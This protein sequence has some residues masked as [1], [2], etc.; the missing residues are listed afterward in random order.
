[1][2]KTAVGLIGIGFIIIL[3]QS[4]IL[5]PR[6]NKITSQTSN[7]QP[8]VTPL[9]ETSPLQID[10]MRKQNYPGSEILIEQTL[11]PGTNYHQYVASYTSE[12]LKINALLTVPVGEKPTNGWP[13]IVF[14][15]GYIAPEVY[16][17]TERYV[18]YVDALARSGYIV[19]KPDYRGNGSSEGN[20]DGAYYSPSYTIDV[21]NA[22]LSIKKFKDTDPNKIGMWGHSMGGNI[23]LR[24]LVTTKDVKAAVIWGGVV[25]SYDDLMNNWQRKVPYQPSQRDLA[26]RN[27]RRGDMVKKF[28]TPKDNPTFWNSI[29]PTAYVQD[30]TAPVQLDHGEAD[31]EVPVAFSQS[32]YD[33]M[34]SAGK[35]V[36]LYTYPGADHNI[37]G[38][39]FN[40]AMEHTI[41]FFNKYLK[42]E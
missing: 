27:N 31:E 36:E 9:I 20:P 10:Y 21:L 38:N 37:S 26:L 41:S 40:I 13:V 24:N 4:G 29:D 17:T 32:L 7:T 42:G 25:G 34:K 2:K 16:R 33:K 35:I 8:L 11:S 22:V 6:K 3:I 12:G 15:H 30:I 28:G 5:T 39:S 1:M 23:T 18:A 14:N 19:F